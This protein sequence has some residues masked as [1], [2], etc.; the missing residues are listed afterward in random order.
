[1]NGCYLHMLC[2]FFS[3]LILCLLQ[4]FWRI[5]DVHIISMLLHLKKSDYIYAVALSAS[6]GFGRAMS[7]ST[8]DD[9][10]PWRR[11]RWRH[12]HHD[13][14]RRAVILLW[15]GCA[16]SAAADVTQPVDWTVYSRNL[17]WSSVRQRHV[18]LVQRHKPHIAAEA[19]LLCHRLRA[20]NSLLA[21]LRATVNTGTFKMKLKT[22]LF[23]KFYLIPYWTLSVV[24]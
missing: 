6:L 18:T 4:F 22:F 20:W 2:C 3:S 7:G 23:C 24:L 8:D 5:K 15:A 16:S 13:N 14:R 10:L 12:G 1:M 17:I 19:A 9:R 11:G 21:D